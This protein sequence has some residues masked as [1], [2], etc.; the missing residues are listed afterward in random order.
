LRLVNLEL[1]K[2]DESVQSLATEVLK[3]KPVRYGATADRASRKTELETKRA[4]FKRST[5]Q[6]AA[7][8]KNIKAWVDHVA[9]RQN[10]VES[11]ATE[12]TETHKILVTLVDQVADREAAVRASTN[13]VQRRERELSNTPS[14]LSRY[15]STLYGKLYAFLR[16]FYRLLKRTRK[17]GFR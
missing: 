13:V 10:A 2:R 8:D 14:R 3:R 4:A 15:S 17:P 12:F 16:P 1:K 6:L 7:S 9:E 5:A 11:L